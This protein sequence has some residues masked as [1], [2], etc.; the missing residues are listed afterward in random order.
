MPDSLDEMVRLLADRA[1]ERLA[2]ATRLEGMTTR[3]AMDEIVRTIL[4]EYRRALA[5]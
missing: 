3:E 1:T 4:E 5:S 2:T